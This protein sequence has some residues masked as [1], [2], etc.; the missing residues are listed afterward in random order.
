MATSPSTGPLAEAFRDGLRELGYVEGQNLAIEY[1]DALGGSDQLREIAANLVHVPVDILVTGGGPATEAAKQATSTLPIVFTQSADPVGT[2]LVASLAR[3]GGNVTGLTNSAKDLSAK[4]LQLL[5]ETVPGLSSVAVLWNPTSPGTVE[6]HA[7]TQEAARLLGLRLLVLEV[8]RADDL[9]RA[10]E[11]ASEHRAE[12]L[13]ILGDPLMTASAARLADLAAQ[14]R[15]PAIYPVRV[16]AEEGGLMAYG[17]D[18]RDQY[19]RAASYVD[20][21]LKGANPADLPVEQPMRFD[22][23]INLKTAQ[24][25]GLTI[26]Q[27][28]LIQATEVIQ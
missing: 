21:I 24:A 17:S 28:V 11:S 3:P 7:E 1:R 15:L 8:R 20:K 9:E 18:V 27:H 5:K 6:Q 26:P 4:R 19:R 13:A 2:G 16:F 22:L 12:A 10:F 23:V 14:R 25:L